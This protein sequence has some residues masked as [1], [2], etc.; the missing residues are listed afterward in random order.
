MERAL[1]STNP[2]VLG[3]YEYVV[4]GG[5]EE[6]KQLQKVHEPERQSLV[7]KN[8]T[9]LL[10]T[11][12]EKYDA[13][14]QERFEEAQ[15]F[16]LSIMTRNQL[17]TKNQTHI[18]MTHFRK[19]LAMA[20]HLV[21]FAHKQYANSPIVQFTSHELLEMVREYRSRLDHTFMF[22]GGSK[23]L[24]DHYAACLEGLSPL[25]IKEFQALVG[26]HTMRKLKYLS[27]HRLECPDFQLG[28]TQMLDMLIE[29]D[30]STLAAKQYARLFL[31]V[32]GQL[33]AKKYSGCIPNIQHKFYI[34]SNQL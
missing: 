4:S 10:Q 21:K 34:L 8:M 27:D 18:H 26:P 23:P 31:K 1:R 13:L 15:K 11:I 16:N 32:L 12:P 14:K 29:M 30:L 19:T 33:A 24:E 6:M 28:V 2:H 17:Y 5:S 9:L 25:Q 20:S 22:G 3:F 7:L